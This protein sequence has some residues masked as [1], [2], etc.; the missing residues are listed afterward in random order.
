MTTELAIRDEQQSLA[1]AAQEEAGYAALAHV[2]GSGDLSQ[3]TNEQ[4]VGHYVRLCRSLGLNE[5]SRPFDWVYFKGAEGE[6]EKLALYPNQSC[7]AQLRRQHHMRVQITRREIVGEL[8]V[9]EATAYT[10]DGR[11]DVASKYVPLTGKY[12]KLKGTMLAN[13]LMKAETGAKRRVTLSMVGLATPPD[14]DDAM[15]WHSV[16]VDGRG[17]I[18][19]NP[20]D[21]Q[22]AL[23]AD[24]GMARV[25]G[26]PVFEDMDVPDDGTISQA[27]LPDELERPRSEPATRPV[28]RCNSEHW[29]KAYFGAVAD[30]PL[31][32]DEGR[33]AFFTDYTKGYTPRLRTDSLTTFLLYSSDRQAQEMVEV[34]RLKADQWRASQPVDAPS[35]PAVAVTDKVEA[36]VLLTGGPGPSPA[37]PS[38]PVRPEDD[39]EYTHEEWQEFY[40]VWSA[41]LKQR[42]THHTIWPDRQIK[43][44]NIVELRTETL[45]CIGQCDSID[46]FLN[47]PDESEGDQ[48]D[49]TVEA[50]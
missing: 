3:L 29:Q 4:R 24:P 45:S 44:A 21:M 37:A 23:A 41:E 19:A 12:G 47:M 7:A 33:A 6:P 28:L 40:R 15:S 30:T 10:P 26:E 1:V 27:A 16:T 2:L 11:E 8:F 36:A 48:A 14:A 38:A 22:K 31:A 50:F 34:A 5:L 35:Q 9:C 18:L 13:A 46:Y 39:R 20:S 42:D 32:T 25:V 43:R 17:Q 49:E